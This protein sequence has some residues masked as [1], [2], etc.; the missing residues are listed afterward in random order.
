MFSKTTVII[1]SF[2]FLLRSITLAAPDLGIQ[3]DWLPLDGRGAPNIIS[4]SG[5]IEFN[6]ELPMDTNRMT[7]EKLVNLGKVAFDRMLAL[8]QE[9]LAAI[10]DLPGAMITLAVGKRIY[11]ASSIR[12]GSGIDLTQIYDKDSGIAKV[13][14]ECVDQM[15]GTHVHG[16]ACGE[17]NVLG[18]YWE[19]NNKQDPPQDPRPRIAAWVRTTGEGSNVPP[20]KTIFGTQVYGCETILG[21]MKLSPVSNKAPDATGQDGWQFR[22]VDNP[23]KP[24]A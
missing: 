16:G 10:A 23:R 15:G 4:F 20:C 22:K 12:G 11:F 18:L 6:D 21:A 7:D 2:L 24:C 19:V 3:I 13:F 9:K 1:Y 8:H 17:P 14:K 5:I